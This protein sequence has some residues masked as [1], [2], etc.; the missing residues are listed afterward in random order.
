MSVAHW[1]I[2]KTCLSAIKVTN[3]SKSFTYKMAAKLNWHRYGTKLRHRH[4]MYS[5]P[6]TC[7]AWVMLDVCCVSVTG[8]LFWS[9][10]SCTAVE[11]VEM[12]VKCRCHEQGLFAV[13][14]SP[15]C[16]VI[17][18]CCFLFILYYAIYGSTQAHKHEQLT[19]KIHQNYI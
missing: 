19:A 8:D 2:N 3:S 12:T 11:S 5:Y 6:T 13:L 15:V 18:R 1:L 16:A 9:R 7:P 14:A 10:G 17:T 4:S